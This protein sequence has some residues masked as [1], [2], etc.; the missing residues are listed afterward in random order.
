L[1]DTLPTLDEIVLGLGGRFL[2]LVA[3]FVRQF[4]ATNLSQALVP[5]LLWVH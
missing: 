3:P 5:P 1:G 2:F 4:V